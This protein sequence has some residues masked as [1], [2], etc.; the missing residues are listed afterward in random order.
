M[1]L[2][3]YNGTKYLNT[4]EQVNFCDSIVSKL[5]KKKGYYYDCRF[6]TGY[7]QLIVTNNGVETVYEY[8]YKTDTTFGEYRRYFQ[9]QLDK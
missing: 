4:D 2:F 1:K 6:I 9:G 7:M 8:P 5:N 3:I